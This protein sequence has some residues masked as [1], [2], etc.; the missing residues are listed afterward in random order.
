MRRTIE[1]RAP[2]V[3]KPVMSQALEG[4]FEIKGGVGMAPCTR[5]AHPARRPPPQS[6]VGL[7]QSPI[8]CHVSL[9][10]TRQPSELAPNIAT[11][12]SGKTI[13]ML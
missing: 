1:N 12:T 6:S 13:S 11:A 9:P 3:I 2:H 5:G 7:R 10:L 8:R 4:R